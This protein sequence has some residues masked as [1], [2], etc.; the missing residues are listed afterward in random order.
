MN[1]HL[2]AIIIGI[3][4]AVLIDVNSFIAAR[5]KDKSA[6]YDWILMLFR[7]IQ[8]AVVGTIGGNIPG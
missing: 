6:S 5:S 7:A 2:R 8:G 1:S 4:S 3:G